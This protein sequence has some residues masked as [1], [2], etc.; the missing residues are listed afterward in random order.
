MAGARH[1]KHDPAW[2]PCGRPRFRRSWPR[3]IMR[4]RPSGSAMRWPV[5]SRPNALWLQ[6]PAISWPTRRDSPGHSSAS[7]CPRRNR[8]LQVDL[9]RREQRQAF[10]TADG[11]SIRELAGLPSGNAANQSLAEAV[12]PAGGTTVAHLHRQT[13]EIYLF[14]DGSER[15][16]LGEEE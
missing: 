6:A 8:L 4:P 10:I 16:R 1:V 9:V 3:V 7:S 5:S 12:V 13:E 15:M 2:S 11:S 14:T